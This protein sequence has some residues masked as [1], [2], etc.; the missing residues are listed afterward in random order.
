MQLETL[1]PFLLRKN[2]NKKRRL[3]MKEKA[4]NAKA[5]WSAKGGKT[6]RGCKPAGHGRAA[7]L[8]LMTAGVIVGAVL[9]IGAMAAPLCAQTYPN[10]PIRLILPMATGGGFDVVGRVIG[11]KLA[12]QLGQPVVPENRPGAGGNV[13]IESVAKA[14][15]DGYTILLAHPAI[16][17]SPS[18]YKKINYDP[19]KDFSPISLVT[20]M[21]YLLVTRPSS[22]FK[23]LKELVEYAKGNP[24]KLNF[25]TAGIGSAG[26]LTL[27]L[28]KSL[29]KIDIVHVPYKGGG[30]A[31]IGLL[32]GETDMAHL[33]V[34]AAWSQIQAGK[35]KMLAVF[36]NKR[37]LSLPNV[38]TATEA[39]IDNL[40]MS[41][42]YGLLAPAGTPRDIINRLYSE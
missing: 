1:N 23:N 2:T 24:R 9:F 11:Q 31:M 41:G 10:K 4:I 15:P 36:S 26:H 38:P 17:T 34:P 28:L 32:S 19:I 13:A 29:A 14:R 7:K 39:G 3:A 16:T 6:V 5:L 42:W 20:Q 37:A 25:G 22:P 12:E 33:G 35:V 18:L 30:P 21:P 27:E 40:V 8:S